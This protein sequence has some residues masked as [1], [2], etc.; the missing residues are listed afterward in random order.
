MN[1]RRLGF[2]FACRRSSRGE[3][4]AGLGEIAG[5]IGAAGHEEF[6]RGDG[7]EELGWRRM[8][9]RA[10]FWARALTWASSAF[11]WREVR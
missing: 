11:W 6:V 8:A 3:A 2:Q 7:W 4:A 10:S 5:G 9:S 1:L